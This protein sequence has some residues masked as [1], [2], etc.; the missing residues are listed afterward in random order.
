MVIARK[1]EGKHQ[2]RLRNKG[3]RTRLRIVMV[4]NNKKEAFPLPQ[5]FTFNLVD[6]RT[7]PH[8]HSYARPQGVSRI[9]RNDAEHPLD[10][11]SGKGYTPST[12]PDKLRLPKD[13]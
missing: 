11:S 4:N 13:E 8:Y 9:A 6:E 5:F 12:P 2:E 7:L 1:G 3:D 10:L